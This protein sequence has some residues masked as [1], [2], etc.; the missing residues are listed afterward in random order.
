MNSLVLKLDEEIKSNEVKSLF[1]GGELPTILRFFTYQ[2]DDDERFADKERIKVLDN[3]SLESQ[4]QNLLTRADG[5]IATKLERNME[6]D[7]EVLLRLRALLAND[8]IRQELKFYIAKHASI[9]L[10]TCIGIAN[11]GLQ[12]YTE[13]GYDW[14]IVEEAAKA[15][16]PELLV[17]MALGARWLLVGDHEQL[18]PF[19][20]GRLGVIFD[21]VAREV[22]ARELQLAAPDTR[23]CLSS[24]ESGAHDLLDG[25]LTEQKNTLMALAYKV[26]AEQDFLRTARDRHL[27]RS[28]MV[29]Q[30]GREE[31]A[32]QR[33]EWER[34]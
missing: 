18:P 23:E 16:L 1:N 6:E 26:A 5:A 28:A 21:E 32:R 24:L 22:E 8:T 12:R 3:Y 11:R 17:P 29:S 27:G 9:T 7:S 30:S 34:R 10:A 14:V 20:Y 19:N 31:Y 25:L 33:R 13:A 15:H 4:L 2:Q